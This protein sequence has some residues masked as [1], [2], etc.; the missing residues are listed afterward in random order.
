MTD[1]EMCQ[2]IEDFANDTSVAKGGHIQVGINTSSISM[3]PRTE[4]KY[5]RV[6]DT[7]YLSEL[8]RGATQFLFWQRRQR[9][10]I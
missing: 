6:E 5:M 8:I 2:L 4:G 10:N 7:N 1:A 3:T 9:E